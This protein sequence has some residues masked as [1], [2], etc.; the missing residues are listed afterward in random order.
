MALTTTSDFIETTFEAPD[1]VRQPTASAFPY[2]RG[3]DAL[4]WNYEFRPYSKFFPVYR[5][6]L[7]SWGTFKTD[8]GGNKLVPTS[9]VINLSKPIGVV[10]QDGKFKV[11]IGE[12]GRTAG[13]LQVLRFYAEIMEIEFQRIH[14][15]LS[16]RMKDEALFK[17]INDYRLDNFG[18]DYKV[19]GSFCIV[20]NRLQA[21]DHK[22]TSLNP[23]A[24]KKFRKNLDFDKGV[25]D[26]LEMTEGGKVVWPFLLSSFVYRGIESNRTDKKGKT[27]YAFQPV[28]M[29][30]GDDMPK[31]LDKV[32]ACARN[33]RGE[34]VPPVLCHPEDARALVEYLTEIRNPRLK[35]SEVQDIPRPSFRQYPDP[36]SGHVIFVSQT[37][38]APQA[39]DIDLWKGS[40][41]EYFPKSL[42]QELS[43]EHNI[44]NYKPSDVLS[45]FGG[46]KIV[47]NGEWIP[48][49]QKQLKEN[50]AGERDGRHYLKHAGEEIEVT[51]QYGILQEFPV[52][53]DLPESEIKNTPIY[54]DD[55]RRNIRKFAEMYSVPLYGSYTKPENPFD[56]LAGAKPKVETEPELD[57][58]P[59]VEKEKKSKIPAFAQV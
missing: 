30:I 55:V 43:A 24:A 41:Q 20:N 4:S 57:F 36:E 13:E 5:F 17:E 19:Y 33:K 54:S 42:L 28:P 45:I 58:K 52:D 40:R 34:L 8:D 50:Y 12:E 14:H 9:K 10:L 1:W 18:P 56:V 23:Q 16:G 44:F 47:V 53:P 25:W 2:P 21:L 11:D 37:N 49:S 59:P 32:F 39:A 29:G 35:P 31:N 7:P 3:K 22:S 6:R 51:Y 38:D 48:V 15:S 46:F 27:I 26:Y